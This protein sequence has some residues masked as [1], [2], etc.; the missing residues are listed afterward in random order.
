MIRCIIVDDE[1]LARELLVGYIDQLPNITCVAVCTGAVQA[2]S[3]LHE[4]HVDLMFLDIQ[5][6]GI[7]GLNFLK[8]VRNAPKVIFTTAYMEHAVEAFELE[9]V[10]YLLKP[11]TFERFIKA[12]QK[13]L[14]KKEE[15]QEAPPRVNENDYV[16][17]KVD[18]RLVKINHRNIVYA[19]GLGDYIKV[20]TADQTY[21]TY[22]TMTKLETLLPANSFVR[23]HRSYIINL[24]HVQYLEGN[25]VRINDVDLPVGLTYKDGLAQK[26]RNVE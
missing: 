23:I 25:F 11:I 3:V 21:I 15:P 8:S 7:T 4:Q 20:Y 26:L 5:M 2:F 22:L 16:F 12:V 19:E 17:L 24:S 1:P 6:P 10:D 14:P 13:V 9:A 18:K